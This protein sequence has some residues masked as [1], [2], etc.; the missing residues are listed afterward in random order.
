[1]KKYSEALVK[2]NDLTVARRS[3]FSI[4]RLVQLPPFHGKTFKEFNL[5]TEDVY[6]RIQPQKN[7]GVQL[8]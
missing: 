8:Y 3:G 6:Q 4:Y 1:M 5:K 7:L 2:S